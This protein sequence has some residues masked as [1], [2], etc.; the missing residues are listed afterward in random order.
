MKFKIKTNLTAGIVI[1]VFAIIML[2]CMPQQVRLPMYDSGAPSPRIIPGICLVGML[3]C[4]AVLLIQSLV[5]H[6]EHIYEFEWAKEKNELII[7]ALLVGFVA[8]TLTLGFVLSGIV[9]FC[10]IEAFVGE[11]KWYMFVYTI[12]AVLF[13]YLLFKLTFHIDLPNGV[14]EQLF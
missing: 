13:V 10:L 2:V 5:F 1:A 11:R 9:F 3:I 4:S 14:L 8:G 7:I 6:K 12:A